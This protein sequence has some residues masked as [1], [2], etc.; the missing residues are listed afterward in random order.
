EKLKVS[1]FPELSVIDS[2]PYNQYVSP[3]SIHKEESLTPHQSTPLS[4]IDF[5]EEL[6]TQCLRNQSGNG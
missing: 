4:V 5:D 1:L 3:N 6:L 2:R